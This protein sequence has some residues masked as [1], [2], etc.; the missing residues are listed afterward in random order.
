[1][2]SIL[3]IQNLRNLTLKIVVALTILFSSIPFFS[4]STH[5]IGGELNYRCLGNNLYEVKLRVFRDCNKASNADYDA[6]AAIGIF[7]VNNVLVTTLYINFPGA[8]VIPPTIAQQNPCV[9][10][11]LNTCV[12]VAEYIGTVTLPPIAGG[13]QLV[14]QRCCRNGTINNINNPGGQGATYTATIPGPALN[15]NSNPVFTKMPP[16]FVCADNPLLFDNSATDAEGDSISYSICT[17]FNGANS[18]PSMPQPPN[19]PPYN[20]ITFKA[21]YTAANPM[22]GIPLTINPT[23][24]L[25]TGTPNTLGQ[26][27]V[28]VCANEYRNGVLLSTTKRDF[29]FNVLSCEPDVAAAAAA[30][31]SDCVNHTVTFTNNST[32]SA[33]YQW[34]FGDLTTTT[35]VS[36]LTNPTYT[37][38]TPGTFTVT[39]IAFSTAGN[40]C[41]DTLKDFIVVVDTCLP[42]GM[43]L[44][45]SKVDASC[46][47]SSPCSVTPISTS[48]WNSAIAPNPNPCPGAGYF[49]SYAQPSCTVDPYGTS[50]DKC[51]YVCGVSANSISNIPW[52]SCTEDPSSPCPGKSAMV[53][54]RGSLG[55]YSYICPCETPVG[56]CTHIV[57]TYPCSSGLQQIYYYGDAGPASRSC[58]SA[59]TD[60]AITSGLTPSSVDLRIGGVTQAQLPPSPPA[61]ITTL[62]NTHAT[63]PKTATITTTGGAGGTATFDYYLWVVS[64]SSGP[65]A[66]G[67][68]TVTP[69]AG[70]AP[71]N[72]SWSPGGQTTSTATNLTAGTYTVIVTDAAGCTKT[73][74]VTV[75]AAS[76]IVLAQSQTSLSSCGASDGTASVTVS[77]GTSPYNYLW[78]NGQTGSTATGLSAGAY[79]VNVTDSTGC[80]KSTTFTINQPVIITVTA[81]K[82]DVLC[83]NPVNG[84]ATA[85]P[86]G[87]IG[88][89][90]FLWSNGQTT[91]PATGLNAGY[92]T[93]TVTDVNGCYGTTSITV[94]NSVLT[95]SSSKTDVACYGGSTGSASVTAT[96]GAPGYSYSWNTSPV[97]TTQ[98]AVNLSAGTYIVIVTDNGG[99]S[100]S[101]SL[102]VSQPALLDPEPSNTSTINCAG[103]TNGSAN[104]IVNG[105]TAPFTYMWCNGQTTSA[106]TAIPAGTCT[107]TIT[108]ANLCSVTDSVDIIFPTPLS[109]TQLTSNATCSSNNGSAIVSPSGGQPGYTYSWSTSP[110]QTTQTATGLS[111]GT[112]TVIVTDNAGCTSALTN[113]VVNQTGANITATTNS[114][115]AICNQNNGTASV[116]A[117]GGTPAYTYSWNTSP[118]QTTQTATG[119][120]AGTYTVVITDNAGCTG[121]TSVTV[122]QTVSN[123][124]IAQSSTTAGCNLSNGTASATASGGTPNYTYSWNSSPVQTTQTATGLSAGTYIVTVT[125][126]S[127]CTSSASVS[128]T[129]LGAPTAVTA[130]TDVSC[131]G[132]NNGTAIVTASGGSGTYTYSWNTSPVQTTVTATGLTSGTYSITITDN[133]GC[134]FITSVTVNQPIPITIVQSTTT[135]GCN[136]SNGTASITASGGTPGYTYSWNTSPLQTTQTAT[137]L[138]AGTYIVIVTDNLT[139]TSS[140]SVTVTNLSAPAAVTSS[141]AVSCNNGTNGTATV[142]ASGGS[143]TYTYSWNTSPV[144]TT[145]T[146][147]G[148][149]AGTYSVTVTD[150]VGCIFITSVTVTQPI[151]ITLVSSQTIVSCNGG[152]DGTATVT[153]S[154]GNGGFVYNWTPVAQTTQTAMGLSAGTYTI[155]V[156]DSK[157]CT[158]S[159]TNINITQ[160]NAINI[161]KDSTGSTCTGGGG[162]GTA[163]VTA[164]GGTSG[165]TYLWNTNPV[166]TNSLA[167]GLSIGSYI[168]TVSDVNGCTS[169]SSVTI[170]GQGGVPIIADFTET[171]IFD[172]DDEVF[173]TFKNLSTNATSYLWNFGDGDTSTLQHPVH[174]YPYGSTVTVTLIAIGGGCTDTITLNIN[175]NAFDDY[176]APTAPNVFTPNDDGTND[177]FEIQVGNGL[178]K[179]VEIIIFD[180]WGLRMYDSETGGACWDGRTTAGNLA[181]EGTYFYLIKVGNYEAHGALSLFR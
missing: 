7:D 81:A 32:G 145:V 59:G 56:V 167:T 51:Y 87:G 166:Q 93:V 136:Q 30:F 168:V 2:T 162:N 157:G 83:G 120:S 12:E 70:T 73:S 24:G 77:G 79:T 25:L 94:S 74:V 101:A 129:N 4:Y 14:Y 135:A 114:A 169:T 146:A 125:D 92:Y 179:C 171:Y 89:Y 134:I 43:T 46:S 140:T 40:A 121:V 45:V 127:G 31:T 156:T 88:P 160:A 33:T 96:N 119:L 21:P 124:I 44:A 41:N 98:T 18:G 49:V 164:S 55:Q 26:F 110:G 128:V 63:C 133:T 174:T 144:Q 113:V 16:L 10:V 111:A 20:F 149:A 154:G 131:N 66:P 5:I 103:T 84:T 163:T 62:T 11:P 65:G 38:P 112:Y 76:T 170:I 54:G 161:A 123:I 13:Y 177:C 80:S 181:S 126:N 158:A 48:Q 153:A 130:S 173:V 117:S 9:K 99:C 36:S 176:I 1:M 142:T 3:Q 106:A 102:T 147:T 28:G 97:Q 6:T 34:N 35:D 105:G 15:C 23:T 109:L 67:S 178:E 37:Y 52:S 104:V 91:N 29:Q 47:P 138:S 69:S 71:Y 141:V 150:N 148:L 57:W 95:L 175:I 139:C 85:T 75:D 61:V 58:L 115:N 60:N 17:P 53:L 151:I 180:R 122:N 86:G 50:P 137:G 155:T 68:A 22:G 82:T 107:V 39:L 100:R 8:T 72:Y 27:V 19:P 90:T 108:D 165:Y 143:G 172:C 42:C 159:L 118:V 116:T 152:T 78:S 132:G 64:G